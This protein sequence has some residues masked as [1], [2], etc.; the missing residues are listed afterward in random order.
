M[1]TKSYIIVKTLS[2]NCFTDILWLY[3]CHN[4]MFVVGSW[5]FTSFLVVLICCVLAS[6]KIVFKVFLSQLPSLLFFFEFDRPWILP[7]ISHGI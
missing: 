6:S 1:A 2:C 5:L 4:K 3:F 7:N